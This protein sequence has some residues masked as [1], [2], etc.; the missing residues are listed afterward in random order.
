M[1]D[2]HRANLILSAAAMKF[3]SLIIIRSMPF[4]IGIIFGYFMN[5]FESS[6]TFFSKKTQVLF[7]MGSILSGLTPLFLYHLGENLKYVE[8]NVNLMANLIIMLVY[9]NLIT[10]SWIIMNGHL[11]KF[12]LINRMLSKELWKKF[13]RLNLSIYLMHPFIL[14]RITLENSFP[15]SDFSS[16]GMVS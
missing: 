4:L 8:N 16:L 14:I 7:W 1:Y 5:E 2:L 15:V 3:Y 10:L 11:G 9:I 12:S 6:R 13:G